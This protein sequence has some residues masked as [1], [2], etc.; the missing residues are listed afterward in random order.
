MSNDVENNDTPES[1]D[2]GESGASIDPFD[3][4]YE[5]ERQSLV[6]AVGLP[7]QKEVIGAWSGIAFALGGHHL[8]SSIDAVA[9]VLQLPEYSKVP[10]ARRWM[11]GV[12]NVRGN[13]VPIVDLN[14]FLFGR[15]TERR[16]TTRMLIAKHEGGG[17]GLIVDAVEGQ[18][19]FLESDLEPVPENLENPLP[20]LVSGAYSLGDSQF[21]VFDMIR[22]VHSP[23]FMRAAA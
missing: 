13:L 5:Y 16:E 10:G 20:A 22:L 14:D 23:S 19:H 2:T 7:D 17:V 8:I 3:L 12:A 21:G 15:Q 9:E 6:H 1:E 11:C 18:K 4:L